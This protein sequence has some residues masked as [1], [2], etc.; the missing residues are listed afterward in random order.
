MIMVMMLVSSVSPT[1][2]SGRQPL[3]DAIACQHTSIDREIAAH[4]EGAHGSI[5]LS[6]TIGLVCEIRL[7][8]PAVDQYQARKARAAPVG[9]VP[10]VSPASPS[11]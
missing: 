3:D 11:T 4:H 2:L 10:G 6:Q 7:V 1:A 8:F 9:V 5:L